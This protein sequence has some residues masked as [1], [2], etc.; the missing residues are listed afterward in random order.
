M[1]ATGH[2]LEDTFVPLEEKNSNVFKVI[3][4]ISIKE[5]YNHST[6][7]ISFYLSTDK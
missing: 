2:R 5:Q 4:V 1:A 3:H 6:F 7:L